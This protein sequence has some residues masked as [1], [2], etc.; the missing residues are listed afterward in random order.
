MIPLQHI[1]HII[2]KHGAEISAILLSIPVDPIAV[3]TPKLL[4]ILTGIDAP[5]IV[6][7]ELLRLWVAFVFYFRALD[8]EKDGMDE[9]SRTMRSEQ[10][11]VY[12][13]V[14]GA[15]F[16]V[17]Y[18]NVYERALAK[19]M[20]IIK[21]EEGAVDLER[22]AEEAELISTMRTRPEVDVTEYVEKHR[23]NQRACGLL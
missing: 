5:T 12:G 17:K 22:V 20:H 2:S 7:H 9:V 14:D 6:S 16:M 4:R 11:D 23:A 15:D 13:G 19:L 3:E 21:A 1:E 18:L 10:E 8:V